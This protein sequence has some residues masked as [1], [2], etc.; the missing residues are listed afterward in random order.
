MN[1][2]KKLADA[3]RSLANF[4]AN[5]PTDA[6]LDAVM[7][8]GETGRHAWARANEVLSAH[9]KAEEKR[10]AET[11]AGIVFAW[12]ERS[13]L[14]AGMPIVTMTQQGPDSFTVRYGMQQRK[15]LTYGR[16]CEELGAAILHALACDG[17]I[18]NRTKAEARR[19]GDA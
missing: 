5:V 11:K 9:D 4:A 12:G 13:N 15:R 3:L 2:E 14:S 19:D 17:L 7:E 18:D 16:A 1:T 8:N 6:Q 10:E